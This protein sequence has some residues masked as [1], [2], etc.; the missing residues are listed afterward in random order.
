VAVIHPIESF[1]L[2]FGPNDQTG[3]AREEY[4]AQFENL[5]CWLLYGLIDFD[6]ISE[7]LLPELE[8]EDPFTVGEMRYDAIVVPDCRTLRKTTLEHL[9]RFRAAGGRVIFA[10]GVPALI[11]AAPSDTAK[12]FAQTCERIR[13]DRTSLLEALEPQRDVEARLPDGKPAHNLI[14]Q[15]RED[16]GVKWLFLCHVNRRRNCV[17][18]PEQYRIR[19]RGLF[20]PTVYDTM[21]GETRLCPASAVDGHTVIETSMYAEDS[22]LLRLESGVPATPPSA[23]SP[24]LKKVLALAEPAGFSLAEPNV[25]LLDRAEYAFDGGV[26]QSAEDILRIDNLF[27]EKLGWPLRGEHMVQ[28]W[29][30][31]DIETENH[32]L[33]LRFTVESQ[34]RVDGASLGLEQPENVEV[35]VNGSRVEAAPD[36]LPNG[37]YVDKQ[38]ETVPIPSLP[39][40]KNEILLKICF[41]HKTNVENCYLLGG[42]GVRAAGAH[43]CIVEPPTQLVFGDIVP[44]GLP[45]YA[46]N[47]TLRCPF[48]LEA[49]LE[50]ALLEIPHFA[51]PVISAALDGK[52]VG[53][54]ALAPHRL[55]LGTVAAGAHT[56]ELTVYGDRY[57]TFGT[58]HNAN[59]EYQWYGPNSFRTAGSQWT[60]T[61]LLRPS[62]ILD[63]PFI[64]AGTG[65]N[66]AGE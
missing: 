25:L 8:G 20:N 19:I 34:I 41:R 45:F 29:L 30:M 61:Y 44:Q 51:A 60:D 21:S 31:Q 37:W 38:I 39:E 40:G 2:M 36:G 59:D 62:G 23:V 42:F 16:N 6:F 35:T 32:T 54:V 33:S 58:L 53:L 27:R 7:S 52:R 1:W 65:G 43:T 9:K 14:C 10:G 4:D 17:D 63:A 12:L 13:L 48:T 24:A 15:L 55:A 49:G 5:I 47:V 56:L 64:L 50:T 22:L 11:D 18:E 46:G 3:A 26:W 28:P 66:R 57:N